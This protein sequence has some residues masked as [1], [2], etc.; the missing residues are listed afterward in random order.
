MEIFETK[1][2]S[3]FNRLNGNR[4]IRSVKKIVD[5]IKTVGYIPNPIMVNEKMEIIDGQNRFEALKELNLPIQYY[6]VKGIGISEARALNLGRTNWGTLDYI[7]SYAED[8]N[9][10]YQ[11][12][13]KFIED[14]PFL[15]AQEVYGIILNKIIKSGWAVSYINE[16]N[17]KIS[18]NEYYKIKER[19][20][21]MKELQAPI[22]NMLGSRRLYVSTIAWC[23]TVPNVN[24]KR[25]CMILN[26]KY[27]LIRPAVDVDLLLEDITKLYNSKLSKENKVYFDFEYRTNYR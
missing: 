9:V 11:Y 8:G 26:E 17:L 5:S 16:G 23:M 1:D 22:K 19:L 7:K 12:T 14:Y 3:L 6:T 24:I 13:L 2:Y 4:D 25:L 21:Y 20:D 15:K 18:T 27:P 10:S